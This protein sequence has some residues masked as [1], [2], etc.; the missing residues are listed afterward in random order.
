MFKI[1]PTKEI[2]IIY[3][4]RQQQDL[5]DNSAN[6]QKKL[7]QT[8]LEDLFRDHEAV[9]NGRPYRRKN[10]TQTGD[11]IRMVFDI[12]ETIDPLSV[13]LWSDHG[14]KILSEWFEVIDDEVEIEKKVRETGY[15][16]FDSEGNIDVEASSDKMRDFLLQR[17]P[18]KYKKFLEWMDKIWKLV[19]TFHVPNAET[20]WKLVKL[21]YSLMRFLDDIVDGDGPISFFV[22]DRKKYAQ[23]K[24]DLIVN[25]D[26]KNPPQSVKTDLFDAFLHQIF[27]MADSIGIFDQ[28]HV[29][30]WD[31]AKSIAFDADRTYESKQLLAKGKG[32]AVRHR[33]DLDKNFHWMDIIGTIYPSTELFGLEP[34]QSTE[35]LKPLWLAMRDVYTLQDIFDD[36]KLGLCNISI[37]EMEQFGITMDEVMALKD[38]HDHDYAKIP[39][40]IQLRM[41]SVIGRIQKNL[42]LYKNNIRT[43]QFPLSYT[44]DYK[45]INT[46]AITKILYNLVLKFKVF[47]RGYIDE[48]KEVL[49]W[50]DELVDRVEW[51]ISHRTS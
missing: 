39:M 38:I 4:L 48:L 10:I 36:P 18:I 19:K 12:P 31:L 2:I 24:I 15:E 27:S 1:M 14:S 6:K 29:G 23:E 51:S 47:P 43:H 26:L 13:W 21:V 20:K 41:Y 7:T 8:E 49:A 50:F 40:S 42:S 30:V 25:Y 5:V 33:E 44:T 3:D 46:T 17:N 16:V 45:W 9:A 37:E 35:L 11:E 28:I 32:L 22:A 34:I